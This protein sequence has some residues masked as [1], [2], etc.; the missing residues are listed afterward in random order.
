RTLVRSAEHHAGPV[1]DEC[2]RRSEPKTAAAAGDQVN[3]AVQS[4]IHPAIL[5]VAA[6]GYGAGLRPTPPYR[7]SGRPA[8]RVPGSGRQLAVQTTP[9]SMISK[10]VKNR[11]FSFTGRTCICADAFW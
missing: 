11:S 7:E 10:P 4:K 2:L 3:P 6:V 5:P 1:R 9:G 8:G